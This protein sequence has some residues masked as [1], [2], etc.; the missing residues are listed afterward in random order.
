[1]A[2][3]LLLLRH[4]DAQRSD[5]PHEVVDVLSLSIGY[6]HETPDDAL[7]DSQLKNLLEAYADA[8]VSVV[9][10]AGNNGTVEPFFP[11]AFAAHVGAPVDPSGAVPMTTVGALNP[12]ATTI[13]LFS[14]SGPWVTTH[15][16]GAAIVSTVPVTLRGSNEASVWVE[17]DD[18]AD[19]ATVDPDG[20]H[21]GFAVWSGTSF[22]A[23][24]AAGQLA[25]YI[26]KAGGGIDRA[27]AC[28]R[29]REAVAH[30]IRGAKQ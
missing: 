18:P 7:A 19:R 9:M 30:V 6:Y 21:C 2:L 10:A 23:P 20:Y 15:R 26:A 25:A 4:L 1:M 3:V 16:V 28:E 11:A 17:R 24:A 27:D 12:D 13:A 22:A 14:N 8:G 29:G 5:N